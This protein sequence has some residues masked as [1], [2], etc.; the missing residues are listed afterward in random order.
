[1]QLTAPNLQV[2]PEVCQQEASCQKLN[3]HIHL[4]PL[5][6][7]ILSSSGPEETVFFCCACFSLFSYLPMWLRHA[8]GRTKAAESL[9]P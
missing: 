6:W 1:M 3:A 4:H 5:R 8:I 2:C 7:E 9:G